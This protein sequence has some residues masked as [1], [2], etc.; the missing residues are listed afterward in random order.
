[1]TANDTSYKGQGF[2]ALM[3]GKDH[4]LA[5]SVKTK[6]QGTMA[7]LLDQETKAAMHGQLSEPGAG[8][9]EKKA[10]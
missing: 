10:S 8:I 6:I 9:K 4:I 1:M 5:A 2:E 7:G 3:A